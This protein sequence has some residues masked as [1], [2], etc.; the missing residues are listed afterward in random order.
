MLELPKLLKKPSLKTPYSTTETRSTLPVI[1]IFLAVVAGFLFYF[2]ILK[3]GQINEYQVAPQ[4]MRE[5]L[6]FKSFKSLG[7]DFSVFER[8]EFKDLRTFGEVPVKPIPAGKTNLFS[9]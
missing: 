3:P 2:Q 4:V 9:P 6:N 5:Y 1:F 7:L 8:A